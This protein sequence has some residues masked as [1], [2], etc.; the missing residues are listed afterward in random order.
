MNIAILC[1]G[2]SPERDVSLV[3]GELVAKA[4]VSRGHKVVLIDVYEGIDL[5]GRKPTGLFSDVIEKS[6]RIG[7]SVPDLDDVKRRNGGR[8]AKI[9]EGVM[10]VC[11]AAD[12]VFLALHGDMGENGRLQAT[13]DNYKIKYTGSGYIGSLLAMDKDISKRLMKLAG[14]PTP[15]WIYYNAALDTPDRIERE[16]G[17]P[18]VVKPTSCGS[19]VGVSIVNDARGLSDALAFA[20]KY[21]Q[22]F[23]IEKKITGR[24]L[25]VG[26]LGD[27]VLPPIEIIPKEGF[28]DYKNK[29]QSGLTTDVCPAQISAEAT[30]KLGKYALRV[31][32]ALRLRG[33]ARID[34]I[35]DGDGE[36]WCLEANTLPGMTPVS[37]LPQEA[38]AVGISYDELCD[39]IV[40]LAG[41]PD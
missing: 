20:A 21:D 11:A 17:L 24:E 40:R 22:T 23:V 2:L 12:A 36:F 31:F 37:L 30:E 29:Y 1:G 6:D 13:L 15:E 33:Y 5:R 35:M 28:Y 4:L 25:S 38:S 16:L 9:G 34:F 3:S 8:E 27:R 7:T 18:C 39:R 41:E 14:V 26:V 10:E 19:S 32:E